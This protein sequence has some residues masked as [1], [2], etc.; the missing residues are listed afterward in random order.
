MLQDM[1]KKFAFRL[2]PVLDI[3]STETTNARNA[4]GV[5]VQARTR[6]EEEI[7]QA[8]D[9]IRSLMVQAGSAQHGMTSAQALE[10]GWYHIRALK[11]DLKIMY[12]E[13]EELRAEEERKRVDLAAAMQKEKA[14]ERLKEKRLDEHTKEALREEQNFLDELAQRRIIS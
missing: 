3:R 13:L 7:A 2:Q 14:L 5:T 9:H 10:A 11:H 6:K 4:F 12:N 8:E 1:A